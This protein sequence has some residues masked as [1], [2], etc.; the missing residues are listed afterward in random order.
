MR[1]IK[2]V[3]ILDTCLVGYENDDTLE[4]GRGPM[5]MGKCCPL[6]IKLKET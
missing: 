2:S 3:G 6:W 1:K 4:K 5:F